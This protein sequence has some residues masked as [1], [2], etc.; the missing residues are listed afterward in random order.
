RQDLYYRLNV[1]S[2]HL[3]PLR[4]RVQDIGPLVRGMTAKFNAKFQKDLFDISPRAQEALEIYP[5]PG[6]IRQMENVVQQAVLMSKGNELVFEHLPPEVRQFQSSPVVVSP[7]V[8]LDSLFQSRE[9]TERSVILRALD[10]NGY[11]RA[12]A[13]STLGISR[14]TLYKKMK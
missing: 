5:W 1:M 4:E 14:V 9:S 13:A 7:P 10:K 3:P 11:S 2:F 8:D 6:N 12:R